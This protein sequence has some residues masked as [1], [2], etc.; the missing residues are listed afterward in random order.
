[1]KLPDGSDDKW[2]GN[3]SREMSMAGD[4]RS[5][6][7]PKTPLPAP[8]GLTCQDPFFPRRAVYR[9]RDLV[10]PPNSSLVAKGPPERALLAPP[11]LIATENGLG[12]HLKHVLCAAN[13]T[14]DLL[15]CA[16]NTS[17]SYTHLT[18]PTIL[19]V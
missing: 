6:V 8:A 16:G 4:Q 7:R 3:H 10:V 18:L 9:W 11:W 17:V 19:L 13:A 14:H 2:T 15:V 1:M 12:H 5:W